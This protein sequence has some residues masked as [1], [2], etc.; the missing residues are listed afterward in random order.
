LPTYQYTVKLDE[1]TNKI[2]EKISEDKGLSK[3]KTFRYALVYFYIHHYHNLEPEK[4]T[5]EQLRDILFRV[6][7]E[8]W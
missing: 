6:I 1:A 3:N 7:L 8:M 2:L 4:A 5:E